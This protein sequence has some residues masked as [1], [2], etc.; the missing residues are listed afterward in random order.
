MAVAKGRAFLLYIGTGSGASVTGDDIIT[1]GTDWTLVAGAQERSMTLTNEAIDGTTAPV[2]L[3]GPLWQTQLT[4]AKAVAIECA[5]RYLN[6]GEERHL[7]EQAW[8]EASMV[9]ALLVY[10]PDDTP[11]AAAVAA[12]TDAYGTQVFGEFMI[13]S[14][15]SSGGLSDTF[16]GSLS[17]S[18]SGPVKLVHPA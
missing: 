5:F 17:L 3:T 10:P 7:L 8:S 14:L 1:V 12:D 4:G 13:T 6:R 16:N 15:S 18:S 2:A 9:K 11:A